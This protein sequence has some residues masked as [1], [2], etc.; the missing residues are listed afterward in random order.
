MVGVPPFNPVSTTNPI[1]RSI[2]EDS[3]MKNLQAVGD[4]LEGIVK[5]SGHISG[6]ARDVL[7]AAQRELQCK[8]FWG[9]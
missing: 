4:I 8:T 5:E 7:N 1:G 3:R 9:M 2:G 6:T